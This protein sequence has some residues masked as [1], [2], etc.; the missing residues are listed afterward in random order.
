ME[1]LA[2][3][4]E[5]IEDLFAYLSRMFMKDINFFDH[6]RGVFTVKIKFHL[7]HHSSTYNSRG[8]NGKI[9]KT[10]SGLSFTAEAWRTAQSAA[11]Q[12]SHSG[13]IA[14][15]RSPLQL[16]FTLAIDARAILCAGSTAHHQG[17]TNGWASYPKAKA[18][19]IRHP[20]LIGRHPAERVNDNGS[21]L[22]LDWSI[23][24]F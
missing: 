11:F 8:L 20:R 17:Q 6:L 4:D 9:L 3:Q 7:S 15:W 2:G 18:K 5:M 22:L 16:A 10:E 24:S 12:E 1:G 23:W 19:R 21:C 13:L 14:N